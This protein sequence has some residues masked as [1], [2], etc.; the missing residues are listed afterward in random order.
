MMLK[1]RIKSFKKQQRLFLLTHRYSSEAVLLQLPYGIKYTTKIVKWLLHN[2]YDIDPTQT[3]SI[4]QIST[5]LIKYHRAVKV[6]RKPASGSKLKFR[7][8]D[9]YDLEHLLIKNKDKQHLDYTLYKFGIYADIYEFLAINKVN[10]YC[11]LY[12]DKNH[13]L[14]LK[15][16]NN[17]AF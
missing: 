5:L 4:E 3:L 9:K 8:I 16:S 12:P 11:D 7:I 6:Q 10:H 1:F 13:E 17:L 14:S 2:A 15:I